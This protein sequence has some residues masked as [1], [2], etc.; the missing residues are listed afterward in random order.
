[1]NTDF[2]NNPSN[3]K[4]AD[5]FVSLIRGDQAFDS[6]LAF[7]IAMLRACIQ[8]T[9]EDIMA[10]P[11]LTMEEYN[12][13]FQTITRA[14]KMLESLYKTQK[15]LLEHKEENKRLIECLKGIPKGFTYDE[16]RGFSEN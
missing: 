13:S 11:D 16:D 1:M 10:Q 2:P 7:E 3:H 14:V 12:A 15:D 6:P 4:L 5:F 8:Q 9:G